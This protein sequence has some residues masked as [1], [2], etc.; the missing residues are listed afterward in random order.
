M[1]VYVISCRVFTQFA[2][3]AFANAYLA[4]FCLLCLDCVDNCTQGAIS[5]RRSLDI[6]ANACG[7]C[8]KKQ[9]LKK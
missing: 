5:Y 4:D 8:N 2:V 7:N 3:H 1:G 6:L 9:T